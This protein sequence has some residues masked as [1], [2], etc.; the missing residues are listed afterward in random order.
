MWGSRRRRN[1]ILQH[2]NLVA[3]THKINMSN[4]DNIN[5]CV[6]MLDCINISGYD[7]CVYCGCHKPDTQ[8]LTECRSNHKKE[9]ITSNTKLHTKPIP[10]IQYVGT[11][12]PYISEE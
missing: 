8:H 2:V 6:K 12:S 10:I 4:D 7:I 3:K 1:E 11:T 5:A 9:A